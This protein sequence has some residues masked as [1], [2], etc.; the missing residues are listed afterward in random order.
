MATFE[1]TGST[2]IDPLKEIAEISSKNNIWLHVDAVFA[3]TALILDEFRWMIE[4]IEQAD[5]FVFNPHKWMFTN[6]NYSTYF[7]K[8]KHALINT[9]DIKPEYLRTKT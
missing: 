7:V 8:D 3:G 1:T 5:S 2:A 4:V 9:F 6:F